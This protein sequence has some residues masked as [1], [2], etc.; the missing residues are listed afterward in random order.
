MERRIAR[1]NLYDFLADLI[2][3][4]VL[5]WCINLML[6]LPGWH[7]PFDPAG[8]LAGAAVVIA[9][10]YLAGLMLQAASEQA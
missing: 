8:G 5:V 4:L 2:P 3:G 1:F 9:V 7:L 6:S 10:G